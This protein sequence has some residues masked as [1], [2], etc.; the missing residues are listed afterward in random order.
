MGGSVPVG[1]SRVFSKLWPTLAV[2]RKVLKRGFVN[3]LGEWSFLKI[4]WGIVEP[5]VVSSFGILPAVT[6]RWC[7]C[8]PSAS[9]PSSIRRAMGALSLSG[10]SWLV[11]LV[12][13]EDPPYM[14]SDSEHRAP[15]RRR[16]SGLRTRTGAKSPMRLAAASRAMPTRPLADRRAFTLRCG[17]LCHRQRDPERSRGEPR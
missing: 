12:V 9:V 1:Q 3:M 14:S 16:P 2:A 5:A 6:P 15:L 11:V 13:S 7:T 8:R 10:C 4:R 17:A